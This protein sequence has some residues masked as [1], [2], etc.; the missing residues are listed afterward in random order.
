MD[1]VTSD[2]SGFVQVL[3]KAREAGLRTNMELV[4]LA[5]ERLREQAVP[6][7]PHLDSIIINEVEA[8]ALTGIDPASGGEVDWFRVEQAASALLRLGVAQI[9]VI[10]FPQGC[11]AATS[12]G[13]VWRQAS[14]RVPQVDVKS[15]NGAGD[16][17][18]AGVMF[19]LHED[20]P[21]QECLK[22]GVCAAATSLRSFS[23]S[24]GIPSAAECLAYGEQHGFLD[25]NR[26]VATSERVN[27]RL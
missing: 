5:P 2:G 1:Q 3:R 6:C 14:V 27:H 7:L 15:T 10:H 13:Q 26:V 18:A 12:D 9:A 24:R 23:T 8:A 11:V 21:V 16:A 19:G 25:G 4:S 20:W 17:L 22:L